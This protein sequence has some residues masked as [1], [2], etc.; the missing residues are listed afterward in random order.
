MR[1]TVS[2]IA[3]EAG[4]SPAT[5][6]RVLNDRD[7]VRPRTRDIVLQ[8][9]RALGYFG[10]PTGTG[11]TMKMRM[12][13]VL[14]AGSNSFMRSLRKFLLEEAH[15]RPEISA[16]IHEIEGFN[17]ERLSAKLH[18]LRGRTDAVGLVALDHPQVREAIN[19]LA[20]SGVRIATLVSDIPTVDKVGYVGVDNRAAGRL[21]GLLLGRFLPPGRHNVA[22]FIGSLAYRGHEEREMG[23]RSILS[24]EFPDMRIAGTAE[25]SDDRDLAYSETMR[26]LQRGDISGIYS[27]GSG[28]Q[29][30]ARAL[31][32]AKVE[33]EVVF[34]GH[35]L[36][37][38]TRLMLLDRTMDAVVDQ[39]PR[40]EA[41]E[42]VRLL[43]SS[44][45][46]STEPEYLPRLQVVFRENIPTQ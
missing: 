25:V 6:D 10:P 1:T 28:N 30:I 31:R 21:A 26:F 7:G 5:V 45:K 22:V 44:V 15:A 39:N 19:D 8:V 29:G 43:A 4:V 27:I 40:V 36:T 33:R 12:D 24:E 37:D 3:R 18:D 42:I 13:F 16:T 34:I 14:P 41:R 32:E 20:K 35:D 46:G 9:A 2:Q 38:A 23:V 11:T 17:P